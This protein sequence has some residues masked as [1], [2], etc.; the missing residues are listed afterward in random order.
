VTLIDRKILSPVANGLTRRGALALGGAALLVPAVAKAELVID[1]RGGSFQPL[2]IAVADFAG[3]GGVLVSGVITN[4][5]KRSGYFT[6]IDK[7]RHPDRNPPF[8]SVPQFEAWKAAG[9][10]AL[11]TGRVSRDGSGRIKAGIRP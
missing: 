10:Q 1:L 8:D 5:L 9:V 6:P 7:S 2:P 4:N 3:D 11:V